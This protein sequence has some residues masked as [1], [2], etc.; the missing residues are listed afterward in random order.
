MATESRERKVLPFEVKAIQ[1]DGSGG[2]EG[3]VAVFNNIDEVGD[4]IQ[5][6]AFTADLPDW[7]ATGFVGG[8]NHEWDEPIGHP[9]EAREDDKGLFIRA[10]FDAS[11][12][13]Q[14][15]RAAMTPHPV[16]KRATIQRLSIG[17]TCQS[18][19]L[20]GF[21]E[22]NAYWRSV[23]YTPSPTDLERAKKGARLLTRVKLYEGSPVMTP[24][25]TAAAITNVKSLESKRFVD[26]S[27]ETVSVI[28]GA[29]E[30][31]EAFV[32]RAET[33]LEA[34]VKAGR[35]LSASNRAALKDLYDT[36]ANLMKT[37]QDMLAKLKDILD[38][39]DPDR[40]EPDGDEASD[41]PEMPK[42]QTVAVETSPKFDPDALLASIAGVLY[43]TDPTR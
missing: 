30:A 25:N 41:K 22:V 2:F 13:A 26:H 5:P 12:N 27:Q 6:G 24:A 33:R 43:A 3:Y 32:R 4:I 23:G 9:S 14:A 8:I 7:L 37:H 15:V 42:A 39:T 18:K 19:F 31:V 10:V 38:R 16:T 28:K 36:H 29:F 1:T 34:R 17:Y 40:G 11:P 35:V 21:D 20:D